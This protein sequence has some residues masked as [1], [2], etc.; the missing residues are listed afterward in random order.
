VLKALHKRGA[1]LLTTNYDDLLEKSCDLRR[2]GPSNKNDILKFNR[3]DLDGVFHLHGSYYDPD[4]VVLDTTDYYQVRHSDEV[5]NVLKTFLENRTILFIGC[6][7]GLE[8]PNF[9]A[10]LKWAS[11]RQENIP[12]RHCL[13]IRNGDTLNFKL[14]VRLKYGP[15]YQ[16]L[17]PYL[18]K[19]LDDAS[20]PADASQLP[21]GYPAPTK[22]E[23][24]SP[25]R[26]S[27]R[28]TTHLPHSP[29]R[30]SQALPTQ[31]PRCLCRHT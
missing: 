26:A 24:D 20:Q 17:V 27:P 16:N 4:E 15:D 10:L 2:I 1:T 19:L 11:E 25:I 29:P 13:L 14:L 18:N 12:N 8:D 22:L 9:D 23:Y 7:S 3:G 21:A 30:E 31:M 5:Q 6:G 28:T